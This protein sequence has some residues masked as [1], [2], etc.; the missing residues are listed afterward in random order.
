MAVPEM[1]DML[2]D[3]WDRVTAT[4]DE[5][6]RTRLRELVLAMADEETQEVRTH[7]GSMIAYLLFT[8]LPADDPMVVVGRRLAE[9]TRRHVSGSVAV[10]LRAKIGGAQPWPADRRILA[11]PWESAAALRSKGIDPDLPDLIRLDRTDGSYAVPSFQFDDD[12]NPHGILLRI[13]Q[14]LGAYDDP[15]GVADWWLS[16]NVWLH[17]R[18]ATLLGRPD[19]DLLMAAAVAVVEG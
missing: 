17:E 11:S 7:L 1:L 18:P 4:L 13:N 12:G 16:S 3:E 8:E 10:S 6:S 19:E 9:G 2:S 15:W 5:R 14:L